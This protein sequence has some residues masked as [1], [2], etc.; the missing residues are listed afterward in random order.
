MSEII[1]NVRKAPAERLKPATYAAMHL[2]VAVFVAYAITGSVAAAAAVGL[3]EPALQ[4][5]AYAFHEKAWA[6]ASRNRLKALSARA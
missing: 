2:V 3:V 1:A 6:R 4:T 5:V